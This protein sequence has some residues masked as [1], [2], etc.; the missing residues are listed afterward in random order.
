MEDFVTW[1]KVSTRHCGQISYSVDI[2]H[3]RSS[4]Q[5]ID[6]RMARVAELT[7]PPE[8]WNMM[9]LYYNFNISGWSAK[10]STEPQRISHKIWAELYGGHL[11]KRAS[12][13]EGAHIYARRLLGVV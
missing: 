4:P 3:M 12:E 5:E 2:N 13:I 7:K 8:R 9:A 1:T 11:F 6:V 10:M